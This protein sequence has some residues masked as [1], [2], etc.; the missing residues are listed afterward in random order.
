MNFQEFFKQG[1]KRDIP[2]IIDSY[3]RQLDL[4][5][6]NNPVP[7]AEIID[8]NNGQ[9]L[10]EDA[11]LPYDDETFNV[12]HAYHLLEH[13]DTPVHVMHEVQRILAPGGHF[14][15]VV[16]YYNSQLQCVCF[17]HKSWFC[18]ESWEQLFQKNCNKF[19]YEWKFQVHFNVICGIV[20]K[21]MC[22]MTQL[23]KTDK[24]A[25]YVGYTK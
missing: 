15:I 13:L 25:K 22:L 6:G 9:D 23:V 14:N 7:G 21:N 12:V 5:G 4:G 17:E 11:S 8:I 20:E 2:E 19:K 3:G 24:V 10:N 1:M 16:P 18:E